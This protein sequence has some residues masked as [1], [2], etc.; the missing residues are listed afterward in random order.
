MFVPCAV[1]AMLNISINKASYIFFVDTCR[2]FKSMLIT[3][4]YAVTFE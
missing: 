4:K 1:E 2:L 3:M